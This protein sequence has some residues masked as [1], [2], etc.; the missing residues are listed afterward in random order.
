MIQIL[1]HLRKGKYLAILSVTTLAL[2]V[3]FTTAV[4]PTANAAAVHCHVFTAGEGSYEAGKVIV[5]KNSVYTV[6]G[7]ST[8]GCV[9]INIRN[10][11]NLNVKGDNCATFQVVMY[12]SNGSD[13]YY[14][15]PKFVCSKGPDGPVVPIATNVL[16]GTK[17]RVIYNVENI[18]WRHSFQIVD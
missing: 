17:Y 8:S 12:P 18:G 13:P 10:V 6:P 14:S 3:S 9:D 7:T 2:A 4:A 11:Q 1:K 5:P 15:K 16:N